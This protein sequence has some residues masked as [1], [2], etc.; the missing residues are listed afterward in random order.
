MVQFYCFDLS[1][2]SRRHF[3]IKLSQ[4]DNIVFIILIIIIYF[5]QFI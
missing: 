5:D 1:Q 4:T 2:G 3:R